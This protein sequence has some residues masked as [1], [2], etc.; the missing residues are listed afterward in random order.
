MQSI[1]FR[2]PIR[3]CGTKITRNSQN[4]IDSIENKIYVQM[5]KET[6]SVCDRQYSLMCQ[7]RPGSDFETGSYIPRSYEGI[8]T[9]TDRKRRE[10]FQRKNGMQR[11]LKIVNINL[12]MR[13]SVDHYPK[14][15]S[16]ASLFLGYFFYVLSITEIFNLSE[17]RKISKK[18]FSNFAV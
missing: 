14:A 5:D 10:L 12:L 11:I 13:Y 7:L 1:L 3:H 17:S 2:I 15:V 18:K 16:T 9:G 6:R 8:S 4:I